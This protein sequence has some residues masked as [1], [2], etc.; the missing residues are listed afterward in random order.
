M[1]FIHNETG[2]LVIVSQTRVIDNGYYGLFMYSDETS[3]GFL[4][5]PIEPRDYETITYIGEL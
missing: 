3:S 4:D 1:I 5:I 2:R